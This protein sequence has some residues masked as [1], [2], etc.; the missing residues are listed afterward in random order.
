MFALFGKEML[1]RFL[2]SYDVPESSQAIFQ[3]HL[4]ELRRYWGPAMVRVLQSVIETVGIA[5]A[6]AVYSLAV[7]YGGRAAIYIVSE[8]R[9]SENW[10][11]APRARRAIGFFNEE[12]PL[13]EMERDQREPK[14]PL[15]FNER[16]AC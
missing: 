3:R 8:S 11:E 7:R 4:A 16:V 15:G 14:L 6:E 10:R 9:A 12:P 5:P 13:I 2:V 1:G